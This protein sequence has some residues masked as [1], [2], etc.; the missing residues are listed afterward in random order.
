[1]KLC[2]N[3]CVTGIKQNAFQ[4]FVKSKQI[5]AKMIIKY[6][7]NISRKSIY[8][9]VFSGCIILEVFR[10]SYNGLCYFLN[11]QLN[12]EGVVCPVNVSPYK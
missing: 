3:V 10:K 2:L 12:G 1:M 11:I 4:Q 7:A 5:F 6:F 8:R 9:L